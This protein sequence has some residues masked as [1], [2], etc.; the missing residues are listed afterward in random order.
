MVKHLFTLLG[1]AC[2]GWLVLSFDVSVVLQIWLTLESKLI[3]SVVALGAIVP[4]FKFFRWHYLLQRN[5]G[6]IEGFSSLSIFSQGLFWGQISP[7]NVGEI[8][9]KCHLMRK[10]YGHPYATSALLVVA[11]RLY[12][13]VLLAV[14]LTLGWL[15]VTNSSYSLFFGFGALL[16]GSA[17]VTRIFWSKIVFFAGHYAQKYDVELDVSD[18][19]P[20]VENIFHSAFIPLAITGVGIVIM[21]LQGSMLSSEGYG[22]H[23]SMYQ[24]L[25]II[26]ALN[27]FRVLP[28]SLFGFGT[29]EVLLL[30]LVKQWLPVYYFPEKIIAF[31]L[32]L[33]IFNLLTTLAVSGGMSCL[34]KRHERINS[35]K[36]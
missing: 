26:A 29:S 16:I 33:T 13:V 9:M 32:S 14:S 15:Y 25:F 36:K 8:I 12:D 20:L 22:L 24:M 10:R 3:I 1:L 11:D 35:D 27:L 23:F 2:I 31:S 17:F 7:G 6:A 4:V 28:I 34:S 18:L 21:T 30:A 19:K 5:L